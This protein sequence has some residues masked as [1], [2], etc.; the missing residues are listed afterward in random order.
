[1]SVPLRALYRKYWAGALIRS[2]LAQ[3][4]GDR[5]TRFDRQR[6]LCHAFAFATDSY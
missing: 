3:I 1:M 2:G 5:C 4:V 6:H